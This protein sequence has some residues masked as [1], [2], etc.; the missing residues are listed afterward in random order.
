MLKTPERTGFKKVQPVPPTLDEIVFMILKSQEQAIRD[1][2]AVTPDKLKTLRFG[3]R[4]GASGVLEFHCFQSV[5]A[6]LY[7]G[8]PW[9]MKNDHWNKLSVA[10]SGAP[11]LNMRFRGQEQIVDGYIAD[12]WHLCFARDYWP[13]ADLWATR[14]HLQD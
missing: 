6:R 14:S 10:I 11:K 2:A 1:L 4:N 3:L 9:T 5:L 13:D 8:E 7:L 12:R